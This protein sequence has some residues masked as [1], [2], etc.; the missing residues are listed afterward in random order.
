MKCFEWLQ[1][2][3]LRGG[4]MVVVSHDLP[5]LDLICTQGIYLHRGTV[6]AHSTMNDAIGTYFADLAEGVDR[7]NDLAEE[8]QE[9]GE[10]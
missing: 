5:A 8:R 1:D 10:A 6:R 4:S 9:P 2:F 7:Q 3:R